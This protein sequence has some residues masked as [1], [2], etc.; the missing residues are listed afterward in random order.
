MHTPVGHEPERCSW[1]IRVGESPRRR[2][3]VCAPMPA[4]T[5]VRQRGRRR[6]T[7]EQRRELTRRRNGWTLAPVA[8]MPRLQLASR[9]VLTP[10]SRKISAPPAIRTPLQPSGI[11]RPVART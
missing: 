7:R 5:I 6:E 8:V 9:R 3:F 1:W 4:R 11:G 2:V 10:A